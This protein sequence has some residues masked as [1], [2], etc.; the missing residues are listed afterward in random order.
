MSIAPEGTGTPDPHTVRAFKLL[1]A[2]SPL[3]CD[4]ELVGTCNI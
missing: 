2:V 4:S 1:C 3:L